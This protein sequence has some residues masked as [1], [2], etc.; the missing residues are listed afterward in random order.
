MPAAGSLRSSAEDLLRFLASCLQPPPGALGD[1]LTLAQQP[2]ARLA[3]QI[4]VGLCWLVLSTPAGGRV[5]WHNAAL[6]ASAPSPGSHPARTAPRSSC[7]TW[8]KR[9]PHR[10]QAHAGPA[11]GRQEAR[12][13]TGTC[14][15]DVPVAQSSQRRRPARDPF[16][17]TIGASHLSLKAVSGTSG[18]SEP[19]HTKGSMS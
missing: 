9:G 3:G 15:G 13:V 11:I 16:A 17:V 6:G 2:Q 18:R 1:A 19:T 10:S 8:A 5:V 12:L 4:Q 14:Y 7:P